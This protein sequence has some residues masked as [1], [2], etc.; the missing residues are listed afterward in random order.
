MLEQHRI[1]QSLLRPPLFLGV[2]RSLFFAASLGGVP[3]L[4]YGNLTLSS[5]GILALYAVS[6][7][8]ICTRLTAKDHDL[9]SLFLLSLRYADHYDPRPLP[10]VKA[11]PMKAGRS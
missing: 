9:L 7:Y 2:E 11:R 1:H 6:A 5:L 8:F 4:G 3:I 10:G